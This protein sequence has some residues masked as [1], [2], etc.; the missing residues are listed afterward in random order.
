M[1]RYAKSDLCASVEKMTRPGNNC[2]PFICFK[3]QFMAASSLPTPAIRPPRTHSGTPWLPRRC[4]SA[5]G[6]LA[7]RQCTCRTEAA[8]AH[9]AAVQQQIQ[10]RFKHEP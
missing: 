8:A 4:Q 2:I 3:K 6:P 9:A 5:S 1:G 10:P 7:M